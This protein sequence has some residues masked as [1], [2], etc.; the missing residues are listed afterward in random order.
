M[1]RPDALLMMSVAG[2]LLGCYRGLTAGRGWRKLAWYSLM[3]CFLAVGFLTKNV[4]AW[5]V[6]ALALAVFVMWERRWRELM[7]WELAAP[8]VIQLAAALPWVAAVGARPDGAGY[9]QAF[10]VNNL[11]GRF[12]Q[13]PGVG[14]TR[15]HPGSPGAYLAQLPVFLLPWTF[16]FIAAAAAAWRRSATGSG[17]QA[18]RFAVASI[19]PGLVVLSAS[20]TARDI[21][22]GV[23]MPGFA[24][25][26]GVWVESALAAAGRLDRLMA[27]ATTGMLGAVAF[28]LPPAVL[29]AVVRLE[30]PMP[31]VPVVVLIGGWIGASTLAVRSWLAT[32]RG[33]LGSSLAGAVACWIV[34]WSCWAPLAFPVINRSQ[35]IAPVAR[36]TAE[37]ASRHPVALW[38][39]D[40]TIIAVM[41]L[42]AGV[43]P[44]RIPDLG[45]LR[46]ALAASPDLHLVVEATRSKSMEVGIAALER[47]LG[48]RVLRRIDLPPPG[49][50]SYVIL[51]PPAVR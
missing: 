37:V 22:A 13:I 14:Y 17:R 28:L 36:A 31:P 46:A 3:H 40:E 51:A 43:T 29:V 48:F 16:F 1:R 10:F 30:A 45:R 2:A 18:W 41:D 20:A 42:E 38:Q 44:P 15:S 9:L 12:T 50:R 6:P 5:I 33:R 19:V 25:L 49:G 7:A 11:V 21:Y 24:L 32:R 23:L 35:D 27:K 8:F 39:P 26:G 47:Q 4:V 34:A